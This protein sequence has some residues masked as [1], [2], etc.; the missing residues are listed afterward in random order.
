MLSGVTQ[1]F[2]RLK[3]G[4]AASATMIGSEEKVKVE[5]WKQASQWSFS[6]PDPDAAEAVTCSWAGT[7]AGMVEEVAQEGISAASVGVGTALGT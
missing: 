3:G 7:S 6:F 2:Y 1:A 4:G 5:L